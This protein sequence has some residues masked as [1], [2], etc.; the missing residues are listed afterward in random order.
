LNAQNDLRLSFGVT[1]HIQGTAPAPV[2]LK[3][4]ATPSTVFPGDPVMVTAT[5]G[6]L[7]PKLNAVYSWSGSGVSGKGANASVDT[8]A[9]APGT[10]TVKV[11]VKEGK[12]GKEGIK[13]GESAEASASFTVKQF[14]PPT[15]S[16]SASPSTIKPG[17]STTITATGVSPQN[18]TLTYHYSASAG[19][20]SGNG[21]TAVYSSTGAPTGTATITGT[22]TDDK[23]QTATSSTDVT[24]TAPYVA[25]IP[26]TQAL[27]PISFDKDKARPARVDNEAKAILDGITLDLEKQPDATAVVVGES[28]AAE[29]AKTA[30][31]QKAALQNKRIKVEDL[32]AQ[33]A[34]NAKDYLVTDKGIDAARIRVAAGAA[35]R[36]AAEI[37]L[38]PA[39]ANFAADVPGTTPVDES[40]VKPQER[41]PLTVKKHK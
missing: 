35:D 21:T 12:A 28:T 3:A 24:I 27:S 14:E 36:K 41:K 31:E 34:V 33:R 26:R 30:K 19:A 6:N 17:E 23:G 10:Y 15:I 22:V 37:Y 7:N 20:I 40:K 2:N 32:A 4:T 25:P 18:R 13:A 8:A 11:E 16:L 9:L 39:G 38:V 5:A 29:K 1:Y